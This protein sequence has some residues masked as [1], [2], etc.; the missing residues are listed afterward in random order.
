MGPSHPVIWLESLPLGSLFCLLHDSQAVCAL[1]VGAFCKARPRLILAAAPGH[2]LLLWVLLRSPPRP[3]VE[4]V[5]E[6]SWPALG[7]EVSGR[8]GQSG[9]SPPNV[10][11]QR[12]GPQVEAG[13]AGLGRG[14]EERMWDWETREK[15]KDLAGVWEVGKKGAPPVARQGGLPADV[16]SWCGR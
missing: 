12:V 7:L 16:V 1:C 8:G 10:W 2:R 9:L 6:P 14:D 15:E 13:P 5:W 11:Q 4:P 3:V